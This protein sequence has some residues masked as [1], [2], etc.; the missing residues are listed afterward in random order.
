ML[1]KDLLLR[2]AAPPLVGFLIAVFVLS[3]MTGEANMNLAAGFVDAAYRSGLL[4]LCWWLGALGFGLVLLRM[5][6]GPSVRAISSA[7]SGAP[8][9]DDRTDLDRIAMAFGLGAALMLTLDSLLGTLGIL[10]GA[11]GLA[12]WGLTGAGILLG[13]RALREAPLSIAPRSAGDSKP[14][15]P[16]QAMLAALGGLAGLLT[17]AASVAPGWLWASEF[18][19]FDALSYHLVLPK[20]WLFETGSVRPIEGNI[21]S[22]LPSFVECAFMQLMAMR[23]NPLE[24]AIACQWWAAFATLAT[25][26]AVARLARGLIAPG[27]GLVAAIVFLA[28]P[29]TTVVG[30]LAYNDMYPCLALASGWLIIRAAASDG[31]RLDVRSSAALALIAAAAFGAK[32][33]SILFTAAPLAAIVLITGGT[34][35]LRLAPIALLVALAALAPWLVRNQLA[36]GS[37]TFPFLASVFGQ[38]PWSGEQL[39][40]FLAAH[41]PKGS[42]TDRLLAL[43]QQWIGYGIG[44][45]PDPREPWYPLW[46]LLPIA[47]LGGILV[48]LRARS[49]SD[50]RWPLAALAA[51]VCMLAGW[52]LAT[53]LKSRFLLPSAVPLALGAAT[54][55]TML[56]RRAGAP[57]AAVATC[58]AVALPFATF[59]REPVRG[60]TERHAPALL[61]NAVAQCTGA[62]L[63]EALNGATPEMRQQLLQTA[64]SIF[65]VNYMLPADARIAAIG[66]STP[67]YL[68][69]SISWSTVWDRGAFDAVVDEAPGTPAVWG[70]RLR[71]K[72]FTHALIDPVM[73]GVW[74]RSGWLNPA[75]AN[76]QWLQALVS[77]NTLVGRG[78]DGRLIVRLEPPADQ[79]QPPPAPIAPLPAGG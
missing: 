54:L 4:A 8:P 78:S 27:S 60:G 5:V 35:S 69:R 64:D 2:V 10:V 38:G 51:I 26:L 77:T 6:L 57:I 61:M 34:R 18:G 17:V 48:E 30:T 53:H 22:A 66:F 29:W 1:T 59:A 32:P 56:A 74:A 50:R 41:G 65:L 75:L 79:L 47:G 40:V 20:A 33:S 68:M 58:I 44:T 45:N 63:A 52:I 21:Y 15:L 71:A 28:T 19:G 55:L 23:G 11:S 73:L 42:I 12:A 36:Y 14:T 72:G 62:P 16:R 7:A 43:V 25:A 76:D 49:S 13:M 9:E 39:S 70:A 24:G 67:F 37:P 46:S 31:R 3:G